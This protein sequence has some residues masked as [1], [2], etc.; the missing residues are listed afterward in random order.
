MIWS[1]PAKELRANYR[2]LD[3]SDMLEQTNGLS[4][5]L[6]AREV[7]VRKARYLEIPAAAHSIGKLVVP[8]VNLD[9]RGTLVPSIPSFYAVTERPDTSG[10]SVEPRIRRNMQ[11]GHVLAEDLSLRR[12][13]FTPFARMRSELD[14]VNAIED[15]AQVYTA[16]FVTDRIAHLTALSDEAASHVLV[17]EN[18]RSIIIEELAIAMDALRAR[19]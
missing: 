3:N 13:I 8:Y 16:G 18:Q 5:A 15:T 6:Y 17:Q 12:G 19:S 14:I 7:A 9:S 1:T 2:R 11:E 4:G 10:F